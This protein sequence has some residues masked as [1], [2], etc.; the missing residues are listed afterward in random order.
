[1]KNRDTIHQPLASLFVI[2]LVTLAVINAVIIWFSLFWAYKWID[3]PLHF[4]G[5]AVVAL[6]YQSKLLTHRVRY[7]FSYSFVATLVFVILIGLLWEVYELVV[8]P[9]LPGYLT[10]TLI[11]LI[12]DLLGGMV[13]YLVARPLTR[14][15]NV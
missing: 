14:L 6:G 5:G 15:E 2:S 3:I 7:Q 11:D 1:M 9:R 4:L 12:M 13:G 8:G 10:D